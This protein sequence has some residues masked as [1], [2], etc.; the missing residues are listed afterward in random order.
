MFIITKID[1]LNNKSYIV[2][3]V[4]EEGEF[5]E[6]YESL[7]IDSD[8]YLEDH[9]VKNINKNRVEVYKRGLLGSYLLYVSFFFL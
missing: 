7:L 2:D 8:Q 4:E 5:M 6:A 1:I 3:V 9:S